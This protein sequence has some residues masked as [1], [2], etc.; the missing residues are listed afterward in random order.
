MELV[1]EV[2]SQAPT[3]VGPNET[4]AD[5]SDKMREAGVRH[6]PVVD[7]EGELVGVLGEH[8][9]FH[10]ALVKALGYGVHATDKV[11]E[12][13]AVKEAMRT[14]VVTTRP[15]ATLAEAAALLLEHKIGSLP[16]LDGNTLVGIITESD[17]LAL[18]AA[19]GAKTR[20]AGQVAAHR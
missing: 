17:F 3:I 8:D 16:V 12:L 14:D 20:A 7:D 13:C 6:L 19:S 11:R 5:A 18:W 15:D 10:N 4:L 9:L 1:R 2:M